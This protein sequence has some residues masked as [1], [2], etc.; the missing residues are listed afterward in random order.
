MY[1]YKHVHDTTHCVADVSRHEETTELVATL[2]RALSDDHCVTFKRPHG[3][4]KETDPRAERMLS[5]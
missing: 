3:L 2:W 1:A 4:R 5:A